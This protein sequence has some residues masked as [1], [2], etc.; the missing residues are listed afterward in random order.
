MLSTVG[1]QIKSPE[2]RLIELVAFACVKPSV[3]VTL[4]LPVSVPVP[5]RFSSFNLTVP[6]SVAFL[7]ML[8]APPVIFTMPPVALFSPPK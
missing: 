8:K 3:T 2:P 1:C 6:N 7:P 4:P 5:D